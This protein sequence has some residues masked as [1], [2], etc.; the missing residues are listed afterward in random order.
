[1]FNF[2]PNE[3]LF[4][5]SPFFKISRFILCT[6]HWKRGCDLT[7]CGMVI[8]VCIYSLFCVDMNVYLMK[9]L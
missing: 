5:L 1:M 7:V 4:P 9:N 6:V 2:H 8:F 3:G